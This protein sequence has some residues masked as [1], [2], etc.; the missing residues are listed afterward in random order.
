MIPETLGVHGLTIGSVLISCVIAAFSSL[1][2]VTWWVRGMGDRR[3]ADTEANVAGSK[4]EDDARHLL[5]T[6][7]QSQLKS[8]IEEVADLKSRVRELESIERKQLTELVELRAASQLE[9]RVRQ[10]TQKASSANE[11]DRQRRNE[12]SLVAATLDIAAATDRVASAAE[13]ANNGGGK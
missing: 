5:F 4:I 11:M 3:R 9:G 7:M 12:P 1:G 10:E 13:K 8:L 2:F 6:Q